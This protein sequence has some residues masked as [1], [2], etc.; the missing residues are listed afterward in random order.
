MRKGP[1]RGPVT[2][3][4]DRGLRLPA[5][6]AARLLDHLLGDDPDALDAGALAMSMAWTTL[7]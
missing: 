6:D 4:R 3:S 5:D 2:A 1:S 7:P